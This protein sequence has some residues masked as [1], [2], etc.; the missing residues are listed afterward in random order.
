MAILQRGVK[1]VLWEFGHAE[2]YNI[3]EFLCIVEKLW[4]QA[5]CED[6]FEIQP[7]ERDFI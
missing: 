5:I 3:Q 1:M 6:I 2:M 4:Q 7:S